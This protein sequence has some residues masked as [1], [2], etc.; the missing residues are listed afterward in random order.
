MSPRTLLALVLC[1]LLAAPAR[2]DEPPGP[3]SL[4]PTPSAPAETAASAPEAASPDG[5]VLEIATPS[6]EPAEMVLELATASA[7]PGAIVLGT[8]S[9]SAEP[10]AIVLETASTSAEPGEIVLEIATPSIDPGEIVLELATPS[11]DPGAVVLEPATGSASP[12]TV[13]SGSPVPL[14]TATPSADPFAWRRNIPFDLVVDGGV[15]GLGQGTMSGL[16]YVERESAIAG[17][18]LPNLER[19]GTLSAGGSWGNLEA[20]LGPLALGLRGSLLSATTTADSP[21]TPAFP[22]RRWDCYARVGALS[23]GMR[24]E[25]FGGSGVLSG[26]YQSVF[27]GLDGTLLD[28]FGTVSLDYGLLAGWGTQKPRTVPAAVAHLPGEGHLELAIRLPW[29]T[30][31][32]GLRAVAIVNVDPARAWGLL[33][34]PGSLIP[35][36][37]NEQIAATSGLSATSW[38][39]YTGPYLRLGATF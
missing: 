38:S 20:R 31:R 39:I 30:L 24:Q 14:V 5:I 27:G 8:A 3:G 11:T 33:T 25:T 17:I 4:S 18:R 35:S 12:V 10:G 22:E 34:D 6:A 36:A 32:G 37:A 15:E 28:L 7:E 9:A 21:Y 1:S 23:L 26:D 2:A 19:S 29:C 16:G 13:A